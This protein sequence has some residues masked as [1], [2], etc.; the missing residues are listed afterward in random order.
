MSIWIN[1]RNSMRSFRLLAGVC[2][3]VLAAALS[4]RCTDVDDSLGGNLVPNDQVMTVK[5]GSSSAVKI[6]QSASDSIVGSHL[7]QAFFGKSRIEG[8]GKRVNGFV[9]QFMKYSLPY[10]SGFGL[11][12]ILDSLVINF[13][14]DRV[15]GGDS[16]VKQTFNVYKIV[17]ELISDSTYYTSFPVEEYA[18][19]SEPL[20]TFDYSGGGNLIARLKPYGEAGQ[21]Y[22]D[23]FFKTDTATYNTDSLFLEKFK[24]LFITPAED[25]PE[26]AVYVSSLLADASQCLMLYTRDHDSVDVEMVKDTLVS[27]FM[28]IDDMYYY[29]KM[30]SVNKVSYDYTGTPLENVIVNDTLPTSP[31][32][33]EVYIEGGVGMTACLR[34]GEEFIETVKS[35]LDGKSAMVIN[36]ARIMVPLKNSS[37]E[38][39]DNALPRLG[40]YYDLSKGRSIPDYAYTYEASQ[41]IL[42]GGYLN[43]SND[44]YEMD[45]TGYVQRLVAPDYSGSTPRAFVLAPP[46]ASFTLSSGG[47][48]WTSIDSYGAVTLKGGGDGEEPIKIVVTYTLIE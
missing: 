24:G 36:Q 18:D 41:S 33:A 17:K 13:A 44:Y 43:R 19:M 34:F 30:T 11:D 46:M 4:W 47:S 38:V 15:C 39:L 45:I 29:R 12:P 7:S 8:Y 3:A 48:I 28:V 40:S 1:I 32:P 5:V 14:V 10:E 22:L 23:E 37:I 21:E 9:F 27:T 16:T 25:S 26:G 6:Y 31:Q 35:W 20:F 42:Y 2:A